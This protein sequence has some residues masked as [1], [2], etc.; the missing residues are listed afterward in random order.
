MTGTEGAPPQRE[1]GERRFQAII[2]GF[3]DPLLTVDREG[4][5]RYAN[6][7]VTRALG[8][9]VPDLLA[10]PFEALVHP[11]D[12]AAVL[13]R[14]AEALAG[15]GTTPL[16]EHR[17]RTASGAWELVET[18]PNCLA[19]PAGHGFLVLHLRCV[20]ERRRLE[21]Q[22]RQRQKMEVVGQLAG[23]VAHDF[24]NLLTVILGGAGALLSTEEPDAAAR[25]EVAEEIKAAASRAA[26]LTRQLLAFARKQ[27]SAPAPVDLNAAVLGTQRMLARL[28]G[29]QVALEVRLDPAAGIVRC[30]PG[31]LEQ[32]I[33]NL[34][35]NARDAMPRGGS[36]VIATR[37]VPAP[38]G[39]PRDGE[40]G[41]RGWAELSLADTGTGMPAEVREHL[42]EPFFTT[43]PPGQGTGLG[44]ATV[45]GIVAQ[46]GGRVEVESEVGRG[47][48]FTVRLPRA[49]PGERPADAAEAAAPR[50]SE[51]VL[52]VEDDASVRRLLVRSLEE[53]GYRVIAAADAAAALAQERQHLGPIDLL[54]SDVVLPGPGGRA[55]AEA[56]GRRRPGLRVLFVSGYAGE[57]VAGPGLPEPGLPFLQK[58]FTPE[59]LLRR[60]RRVLDAPPQPAGA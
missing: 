6:G 9:R 46:G 14:L 59:A 49:A 28:L 36:L 21:A 22:V 34:A 50:G 47:S 20:G 26:D 19:D 53:A 1:A 55:V 48:T 38:P 10:R 27:V 54:V 24:N 8:L 5:I 7:A 12:R 42:F 4:L 23:G 18:M 16:F 35:V 52:V 45:H 57:A 56:L 32:V 31:Q 41:A 17:V 11:D 44:L 3:T 43:K 60:V 33:L 51:C 39:P 29:E 25:R 37:A 30:D 13:A 58:P 2:D 40:P 15:P